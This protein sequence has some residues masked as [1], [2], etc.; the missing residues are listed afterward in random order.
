MIDFYWPTAQGEWLAFLSAIATIAL[1]VFTIARLL[2][3]SLPIAH[4]ARAHLG[5]MQV[6]IG[7]VAISMAQP[8]I[9]LALGAGWLLSALFELLAILRHRQRGAGALLSIM[10]SVALA[11]LPIAYAMGLV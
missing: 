4:R 6:G 9:Y 1:G 8:L 10:T 2:L 5:G 7:L 11:L 3:T